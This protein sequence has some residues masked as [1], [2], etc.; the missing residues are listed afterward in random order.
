MALRVIHRLLPPQPELRAVLRRRVEQ[1]AAI[2][3]LVEPPV[4]GNA[5]FFER[6]HEQIA[7][8]RRLPAL[9]PVL[10][11]IA[12]V[13]RR[14]LGIRDSSSLSRAALSARFCRSPGNISNCPTSSAICRSVMR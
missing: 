2:N 6:R 11:D 1:V 13:R 9:R 12:I 4:A 5:L 10:E 7:V 8:R 3:R 14:R